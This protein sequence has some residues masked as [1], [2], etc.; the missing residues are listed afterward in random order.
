MKEV[1]TGQEK[2]GKEN[3]PI[4]LYIESEERKKREKKKKKKRGNQLKR[5]S[6]TCLQY[7]IIK[8][9]GHYW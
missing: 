1:K 2:R 6:L 9:P 7:E 4:L 8:G 3:I 5:G